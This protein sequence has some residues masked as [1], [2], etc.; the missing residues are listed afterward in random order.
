MTD[1][2]ETTNSIYMKMRLNYYV[3]II[4]LILYDD[5]EVFIFEG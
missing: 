4:F 3:A 1:R 2:V 5:L